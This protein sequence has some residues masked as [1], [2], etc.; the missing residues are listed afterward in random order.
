MVNGLSKKKQKICLRKVLPFIEMAPNNP[1]KKF[2]AWLRTLSNFANLSLG[3][4][5]ES[6][7]ESCQLVAWLESIEEPCCLAPD[8]VK[9]HRRNYFVEDIA[10]ESKDFADLSLVEIIEESEDFGQICRLA[11][12][13]VKSLGQIH[14]RIL[15]ICRLDPDLSNPSK[16]LTDLSLGSRLCQIHRR[17]LPIC[18]LSQ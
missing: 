2:D 15:P 14:R 4:R 12:D 18:R 5:H 3:S 13:F 16:N 1:S 6:I 8:F 17:S 11:P 9:F 10:E 7:E